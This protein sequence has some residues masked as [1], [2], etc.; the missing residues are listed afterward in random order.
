MN[1]DI[2]KHVVK[3]VT[4]VITP[5]KKNAYWSV[6]IINTN[7]F[8]ITSVLVAST[9]YS[10]KGPDRERTSTIR[11]SIT[12]VAANSSVHVELIDPK[13]FH[14]FNE[15]GVT[16]YIG[17]DLYFKKFLFVPDSIVKGNLSYN[18]ILDAEVVEHS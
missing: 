6:H 14:L 15:Y 12:E 9:G 4:I 1:K 7:E 5:E 11:H 18:A 17:K 3:N 16:Y 8:P 10:E 13:V 2:P